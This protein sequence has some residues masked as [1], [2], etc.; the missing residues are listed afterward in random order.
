LEILREYTSLSGPTTLV[1]KEEGGDLLS[2]LMS[3]IKSMINT[4]VSGVLTVVNG[5]IDGFKKSLDWLGDLKTFMSF[6]GG[7][8]LKLLLSL[9]KFLICRHCWWCRYN[10]AWR[11]IKR[12]FP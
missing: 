2:G 1:K 12:L 11:K 8:S 10:V 9:G 5:L 7:N 4:A 3:T 6:L